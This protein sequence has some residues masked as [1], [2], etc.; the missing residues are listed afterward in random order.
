MTEG[1]TH[2]HSH[3]DTHTQNVS[4]ILRHSETQTER[5][6]EKRTETQKQ[7]QGWREEE[8][9]QKRERLKICGRQAENSSGG[10]AKHQSW[11]PLQPF[12]KPPPA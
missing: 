11:G 12:I 4:K 3:T 2:S 1:H 10:Y 5:H 9:A 6:T 7:T 8:T